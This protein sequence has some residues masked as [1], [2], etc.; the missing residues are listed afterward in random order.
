MPSLVLRTT[1]RL[2]L[3]L[4]LVFSVFLLLRGHNAPGGGF[5]GGLV[6]ALLLIPVFGAITAA[7][8]LVGVKLASLA[9]QLASRP[10][11]V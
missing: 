3:P 10:D 5:V 4:L 9:T 6:V 11:V 7:L 2:L 8:A 1:T